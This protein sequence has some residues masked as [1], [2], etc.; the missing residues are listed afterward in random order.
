MLVGAFGIPTTVI[1]EIERQAQVVEQ[2]AAADPSVWKDPGRLPEMLLLGLLRGKHY[3]HLMLA[4]HRYEH[5]LNPELY[6]VLL[7]TALDDATGKTLELLVAYLVSLAP[8][9]RSRIGAIAADFSCE[10]D[11]I[12]LQT[13]T[14]T[15]F[16]PSHSGSVLVECKNWK[17]R[18]VNAAVIGYLHARMLVTGCRLGILVSQDG[19]T[20]MDSS[21]GADEKAGLALMR[22][23]YHE[24]GNLLLSFN[25]EDLTRVGELRSF[26]T[27]VEERAEDF[28]YGRE[29][30]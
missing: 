9:Y 29:K 21:L 11:V 5:E 12:A 28:I 30:A 3:S 6:E 16:V 19:P 15:A 10:H 22:R 4:T 18:K 25:K 24:T 14:A 20:R 1:V 26:R 7:K 23:L 8:G 2:A 13:P 27:V 17:D